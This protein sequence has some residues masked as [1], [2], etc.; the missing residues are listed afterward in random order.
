MIVTGNPNK[1]ILTWNVFV[2]CE[3]AHKDIIYYLFPS[4]F[5]CNIIRSFFFLTFDL[6]LIMLG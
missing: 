3:R 4:K 5:Y 6:R 1:E 2:K